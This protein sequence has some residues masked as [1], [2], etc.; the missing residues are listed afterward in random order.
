MN[1]LR[2]IDIYAV[3]A[4]ALT[5]LRALSAGLIVYLGWKY[6]RES[7]SSVALLIVAGWIADGMDGPLAR[8]S[9]RRTLL[10]RYDFV[11]DVLLTWATFAYL[12]LAG[13]IPWPLALL[14]TLLAM[15]VVA[16]F[17]RKSVMVAFM[18]PIDLTTAV[19]ALQSV[20]QIA[21]LFSLWL[22]GLG[23]VHWRRVKTRVRVWI[24]DLYMT[25]RYGRHRP[26]DKE[27][28]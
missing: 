1:R 15:F 9:H 12:T 7:I 25:V 4:D 13:Y 21:A 18:R 19:I 2:H 8:R 26:K 3:L 20:P 28:K 17:Q 27:C 22:V 10:G 5:L 24:C 11:I 6:G 14:Y 16:Y 23:I